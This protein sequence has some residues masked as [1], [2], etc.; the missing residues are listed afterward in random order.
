[1][2]GVGVEVLRS[3]AL[4]V[5]VY[6]GYDPVTGRR[7]YLTGDGAGR[8]GRREARRDARTRLLGQVTGLSMSTANR[9]YVAAY[10]AHAYAG[11][12]RRD[13]ARRA[14][15]GAAA[16]AERTL[17]EPPSLWLG[18]SDFRP[19]NVRAE[20]RIVILDDADRA[21]PLAGRC[22]WHAVVL[23]ACLGMAISGRVRRAVRRR[24]CGCRATPGGGTGCPARA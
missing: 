5:K 22:G 3:G 14:L 4:R 6:S 12:G 11:A 23:R 9:C 10:Q 7:Y 20:Q 16:H 8:P 21:H 19:A 1:V 17:D 13:A 24:L 15:D 2:A 18:I